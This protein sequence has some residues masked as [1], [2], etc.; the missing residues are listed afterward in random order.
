M[1]WGGGQG[2]GA[3]ATVEQFLIRG[4]GTACQV[5]VVGQPRSDSRRSASPLPKLLEDS[6]GPAPMPWPLPQIL[7]C[8]SGSGARRCDLGDRPDESDKLASDG[9]DDD[10][11]LFP[12]SE[13]SAI[14][15]A[16]PDLRLPGDVADFRRERLL[17]PVPGSAYL[18]GQPVGPGRFDDQPPCRQAA[19][20]GDAG[21]PARFTA[22]MLAWHKTKIG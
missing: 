9:C 18:G 13:H 1:T 8:F 15:S 22:R 4:L 21:E 10:G 5:C 11:S 12:A 6:P 20:L 14:P 16:E 2:A 17:S 7:Q 19:R 3:I